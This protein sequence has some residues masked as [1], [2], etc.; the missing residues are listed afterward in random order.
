MLNIGASEIMVIALIA[1]LLLG[2][3]LAVLVWLLR[4]NKKP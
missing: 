2:P 1:L 3:P 4:R